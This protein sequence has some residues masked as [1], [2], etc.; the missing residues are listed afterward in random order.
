MNAYLAGPCQLTSWAVSNPIFEQEKVLIQAYW[1]IF[2]FLVILS[3][4]ENW[5]A[6]LQN[7]YPGIYFVIRLADNCMEIKFPFVSI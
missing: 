7:G 6:F 4:S 5:T 2:V 1:I 3:S